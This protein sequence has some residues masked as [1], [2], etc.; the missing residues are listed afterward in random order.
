MFKKGEIEKKILESG[1]IV[2]ANKSEN[3][4]KE[5]AKELYKNSSNKPYYNELVDLIS[6]QESII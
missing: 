2:A 1:F 4:T 6:R 3:L 5:I